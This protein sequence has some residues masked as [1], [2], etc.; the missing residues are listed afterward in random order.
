M[1]TLHFHYDNGKT[2]TKRLSTCTLQTLINH[3]RVIK[4]YNNMVIG[5]EFH[6]AVIFKKVTALMILQKKPKRQSIWQIR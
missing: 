2:F 3:L 5:G 6:K 1:K 4:D